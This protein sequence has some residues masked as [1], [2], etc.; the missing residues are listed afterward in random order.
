MRSGSVPRDPLTAMHTAEHILSA[1]MQRDYG[2]GRSLETH[3]GAKKSKCDYRVPRPLDEAA[4]RAIED[5]VNVEIV[6]DLPVTSREV[7]R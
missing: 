7:S 2:S 5:A 6:K 1:V 4:V 3:L